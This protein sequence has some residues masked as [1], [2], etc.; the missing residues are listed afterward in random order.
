[1]LPPVTFSPGA[2][3]RDKELQRDYGAVLQ[4]FLDI[5]GSGEGDGVR[6]AGSQAWLNFPQE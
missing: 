1:V 3:G 4:Q 6:N 2:G 5:V